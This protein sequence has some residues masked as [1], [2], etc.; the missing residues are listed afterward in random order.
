MTDTETST[1][2]TADRSPDG[3]AIVVGIDRGPSAKVALR[4]ALAEAILRRAPLTALTGAGSPMV[5]SPMGWG[6]FQIDPAE[7]LLA[8]RRDLDAVVDEAL[9]EVPTPH[10]TVERVA[11]IGPAAEALVEES[12]K[13]ALVVV[14][15]RELHGLYR[16]LGS[17]SD[18]V[19]MHAVCPVAVIPE[20]HKTPFAPGAPIV[21]GVDGSLNGD[22]ALAWAVEEGRRRGVP[23]R[24]V[25]CWSLFDQHGAG[26]PQHFNPD[27]D[28]QSARQALADIVERVIGPDADD[29]ELT[30]IC[31]LPAAGLLEAAA[32]AESP[33]LV[34]GARGL[35]GFRGLLLGSVS[36]RVLVASNRPTVIVHPPQP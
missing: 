24:A 36:H 14:G 17:V 33:L 32:D 18:Q 30:P 12:V 9:A 28:N 5:I 8:A 23:T 29:V 27:Y 16:W 19:A 34:L 31:D 26:G 2:E 1:E 13:A 7:L 21:V 3:S 25:A 10:P 6:A 22:A 35:G 15:T 4:W 20:L 11:T